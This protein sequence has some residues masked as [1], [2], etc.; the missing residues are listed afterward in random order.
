LAIGKDLFLLFQEGES[1][2]LGFAIAMLQHTLNENKVLDTDGNPI[3]VTL[4]MFQKFG[5]IGHP[6]TYITDA[7]KEKSI[8]CITKTVI[9]IN[10]AD[11]LKEDQ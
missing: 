4:D 3:E 8:F 10:S 1:F 2:N 6:S 11:W 5:I 9:A 7:G